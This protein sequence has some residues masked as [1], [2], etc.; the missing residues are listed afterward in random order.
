MSFFSYRNKTYRKEEKYMTREEARVYI[1]EHATD[2]LERDN[3]GKGYICPICGSGN[4]KHGTG[5]T[6]KDREHFTCWRGCFT[7]ADIFEII[8]KQFH[9]TDFAEQFTK[10]CELSGITPD[11]YEEA[12]NY[13]FTQGKKAKTQP[14]PETEDFSEFCK[15]ASEHITETAY[16]RGISLETLKR[17]G[18]G[19][20][21]AWRHPKAPNAPTSP[22]LIIPNGYGG[23]LAR[24]TR[25][26][27]TEQQREYSK[28]RAGKTGLFNA[29][30]L[31][32]REQP[33][34]VVEGE[35]DALSIIDAGGEAIALC[36]ISN[37]GRLLEAVSKQP[38]EIPL[39]IAL[40]SDIKGQETSEKLLAE[41]KKLNFFSYR[42]RSL[43][44]QYKDANEFFVADRETFA[45][46]VK[47]GIQEALELEVEEE[48]AEKREAF[49]RESVAYH[50]PEFMALVKTNRDRPAIPTGFS[51]LDELLYGGLYAGLYFVGAVSSLGKTTL[52]LQIADSVAQAGHG[53]LIFS[54][55]MARA[56]L[57]AKALSR[58]TFTG[59]V[60]K[61]GNTT[62]AMTTLGILRGR[63]TEKQ[64]GLV[65]GA[66]REYSEWGQREHVTIGV[67]D[68]GVSHVR[69]KTE[70]Y[71]KYT[72][73]PPVVVIDYLQILQNPE[74]KHSL[75]DKQAVDKNVLELKRISRDYDT[76]V[77]GISSFNR[78]NYSAP[79]S[80]ASFKES[81]AIE[82]SADVLI[83]LQYYGLDYQEEEK[84]A[85]RT[86]RVRAL[87]KKNEQLGKALKSQD[88]Q[89]KVLKNRNGKR[90]SCR[91]DFWP[92]FNYFKAKEGE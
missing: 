18:V 63:F 66:I 52:A 69:E 14:K 86:G 24:D 9:I 53:A 71:I 85:Q 59:S 56:E 72:G 70:E 78:E 60:A 64:Q 8:G 32:Q 51:N 6:T 50:L 5:I 17:F 36:S 75:T 67:G 42:N 92:A 16:H 13:T 40:D 80:T 77:I 35:F 22:R 89:L 25:E 12:I 39:I 4:G 84:D 27:L 62:Y 54:L 57:M 61:Y 44:E 11:K 49:E 37:M 19:Y 73:K 83:G 1:R 82:Y 91:F 34:F 38:P 48:K 76:P 58:M 47:K 31:A 79:V 65:L 3:S 33:V 81:G 43:P 15:K 28:Q 2:Y 88:I 46:W 10:A 30:A 41:L 74:C 87:I 26:N 45:A 68:V 21:P 29:K 55:E 7:N 20:V 90:G 23:Y